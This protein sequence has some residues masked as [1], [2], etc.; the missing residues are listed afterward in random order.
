[1]GGW[2]EAASLFP[3]EVEL[4]SSFPSPAGRRS[5]E[6]AYCACAV[7]G[8]GGGE[9]DR[10][11]YEEKRPGCVMYV[12]FVWNIC[13]CVINVMYSITNS[14]RVLAFIYILSCKYWDIICG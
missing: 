4:L 5:A 9:H 3:T 11:L 12:L 2:R 6:A 10:K 7:G 1:M 13:V 14:V 8:T